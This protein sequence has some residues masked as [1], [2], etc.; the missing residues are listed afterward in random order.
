MALITTVTAVRLAKGTKEYV[1]LQVVDETG[2]VT[3]LSGTTPQ[4]DV[5]PDTGGAIQSAVACVIGGS[6]MLL[7]CLV[8]TTLAGYVIGS[9]YNLYVYW[10]LGPENP[11][12][13]PF[14]IYII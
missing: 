13:G 14:D 10:T 6:G 12:E 5:F 3:T 1:D 11:R 8:D 4:F 9:H 7:Q 2:A